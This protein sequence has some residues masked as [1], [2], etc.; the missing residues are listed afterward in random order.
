MLVLSTTCFLLQKQ[1]LTVLRLYS[2]VSKLCLEGDGSKGRLCWIH[3]QR[4]GRCE[5][6]ISQVFRLYFADKTQ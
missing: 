4:F 2:Y 6:K 3:I 1:D 5:R